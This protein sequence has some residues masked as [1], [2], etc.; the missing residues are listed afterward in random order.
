MIGDV[1]IVAGIS[2]A[3][4]GTVRVTACTTLDS[5]MHLQAAAG[6]ATGGTAA[7]T[8]VPTNTRFWDLVVEGFNW[9]GQWNANS[10]YQLGDVVNETVTPMFLLL[11]IL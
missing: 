9:T 5:L 4:N 6:G 7:Y 1:V 3:Y 8:P 10:V 11:Q 2:A